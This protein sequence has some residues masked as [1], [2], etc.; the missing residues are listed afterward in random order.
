M[1][2]ISLFFCDLNSSPMKRSSLIAC[3]FCL[4]RVGYGQ[5]FE[6]IKDAFPEGTTFHQ[7]LPYAHDT[8][9]KHLLDLYYPPNVKGNV[10]LV[11]WVHG[12]G[13]NQ[14]DKYDDM[15]Y[16][17]STIRAMLEKGYALA[18]IDYRLS[19]TVKFPAQIQDCN[20]AV[21]FL[22]QH[23]ADYKIDKNEFVLMG[24]SAG[25]HLASLLALSNNSNIPDFYV[26]K[27]KPAFKIQAVVNFYGPVH[28]LMFYHMVT[29][30]NRNDPISM[31][32]G[33][34]P[35]K[36][37][38]L[39]AIASPIT[40]VDKGDPA[41]FIVH[42]EKDDGV[43]VS[44]SLLLKSALDLANVKNQLVVVKDA[45]HF[46]PMFDVEE[47]RTKLMAFLDSEMR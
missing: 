2:L 14:N 43:P 38:D 6:D 47:V 28:L 40:Y 45:P 32:L 46:G 3:L 9:R 8:L 1:L 17:K 30:V 5:V 4:V 22:S 7:N 31:L 36:R 44:Q 26:N 15:I 23:A 16:M 21:D 25:G 19:T 12:G 42:G 34:T 33:A 27:K 11:I 10:P 29:D 35:L 39:S 41:F 18:S 24:F 37:P 20:Q 13:W